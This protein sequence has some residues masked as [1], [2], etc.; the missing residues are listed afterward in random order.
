M[1]LFGIRVTYLDKSALICYHPQAVDSFERLREILIQNLGNDRALL[2]HLRRGGAISLPGLDEDHQLFVLEW[3]TTQEWMP[4]RRIALQHLKRVEWSW[5]TPWTH[6][7][8]PLLDYV[9]R[10]EEQSLATYH[11]VSKNLS[12]ECDAAPPVTRILA[13]ALWLL[14][15]PSCRPGNVVILDGIRP[16][17]A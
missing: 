3:L 5:E 2:R 15:A 1:F 10:P 8:Q 13:R 12:W 9:A 11:K 14:S 7:I 4:I 6:G 16:S 17:A